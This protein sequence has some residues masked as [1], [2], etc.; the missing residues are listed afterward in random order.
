MN[1]DRKVVPKILQRALKKCSRMYA[2][3]LYA[4]C[5]P[6]EYLILSNYF[7]YKG[8][9]FVYQQTKHVNKG[10]S[11]NQVHYFKITNPAIDLDEFPIIKYAML[12][13]NME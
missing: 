6:V 1:L 7:Q 11:G 3:G 10:I 5:T 4:Y 12:D 13:V 2:N 9:D 8:Y